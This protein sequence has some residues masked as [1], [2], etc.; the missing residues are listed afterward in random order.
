MGGHTGP[1]LQIQAEHPG[2]GGSWTRPYG[3]IEERPRCSRRGRSQT[4]PP[5][6]APEALA[7][8]NQAQEWNRTSNN[9]CKP[10][11]QWPGR[12][13]TQ[14]LLI[15]RAGSPA[16]SNSSAS[17]VK[18]VRGK[19]TMSTKCSSGAV[20][21]GVLVPFPPWAKELAARR[22]RNPLRNPPKAAC[23]GHRA[24]QGCRK[25]TISSPAPPGRQSSG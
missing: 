22:R 7:R 17:P 14:A 16:T 23:R 2:T 4:G 1:L 10:R 20:P 3:G 19:A 12:N 5:G 24:P 15:L 25:K 6:F 11:A 18:G 9:F 13:R 8:Q 21:G